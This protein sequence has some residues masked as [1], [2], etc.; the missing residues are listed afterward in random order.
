MF[1]NERNMTKKT[2]KLRL[3]GLLD[4]GNPIDFQVTRLHE[5]RGVHGPHSLTLYIPAGYQWPDD[6][7][8]ADVM[9]AC[10]KQ[11]IKTV[12][13]Y[14][15][16]PDQPGDGWVSGGTPEPQPMAFARD[17][18]I[19]T[20]MGRR[21][22]DLM[23]E[24]VELFDRKHRDY[25]PRNILSSGEPGVVV[26]CSDKVERLRHLLITN[27]GQQPNNEAIEDSWMDLS[28]HAAIGAL[29]HKGEWK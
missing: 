17:P 1:F 26:R 7:S 25:G 14:D 13:T 21:M 18:D 15:L 9:E 28:V 23:V 27:P 20:D 3:K 10:R 8:R 29:V 12:Q 24:L 4:G 2:K 5:L 11:G 19:Q 22:L 6:L 16:G